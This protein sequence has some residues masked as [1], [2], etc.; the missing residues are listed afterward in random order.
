MDKVWITHSE[1][2][3]DKVENLSQVLGI[4]SIL[5][6]ILVDRGI[7]SFD[8][9]KSFFRPNL[10]ELHDPFLM[11]DMDKAVLRLEKALKNNENILIYGDYDVDGTTSVALVYN[12]LSAYSKKLGFYVPDRYNEGY[13]ISINGV[14]YAARNEFSLVIALDCGIKAIERMKLA[15]SLGVDFIICDHHTP[16][17]EQLPEAVAVLDP[18]RKDCNYPFKHLSGCGVG[19]KLLQALCI[20]QNITES[21]LFSMLDLVAVSIASDIVSLTGENRI[22]AHYGLKQLSQNPCLGLK[23]LKELGGIKG[24]VSINDVVFKIGPRINAAGRIRTADTSVQLLI[25]K[26]ENLA[27]AIAEEIQNLNTQRKNL[28]QHITEEAMLRAEEQGKTKKGLVLYNPEWSKGVVGIV[29]SRIVEK[30]YKPTIILTQE[31]GKITGSARSIEGFDLYDAIA[32]CEDLLVNFGGHK[33]AAGL[34]IKT[35]KLNEFIER[36]E[37]IVSESLSQKDLKPKIYIDARLELSQIT[38]KFFRILKQFEPLGPDNMSPVFITKDVIDYGISRTVGKEKQHLRLTVTCFD[39]ITHV[40]NGIAFSMG[41]FYEE[42]KKGN[43]FDICYTLQENN[44]SGRK[45]IQLQIKD[46]KI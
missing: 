34:T 7:D 23:K 5:C 12:F 19:F 15:K 41:H 26:D 10:D 20:H 21:R 36:F 2:K 46:I 44:Y 6:K 27:D 42:I 16:E 9:A 31:N 18:M 17:E 33:Y 4:D 3:N 38:P 13:G 43:P 1:E 22:L 14:E 40:K 29:A 30:F 11:K 28:D 25:T 37:Q 24:E 39:N 32:Q 8:K 45:E 35:E